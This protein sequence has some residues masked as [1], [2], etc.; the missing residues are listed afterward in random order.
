MTWGAFGY[1]CYQYYQYYQDPKITPTNVVDEYF[2][3]AVKYVDKSYRKVADLFTK[4]AMDKLLPEIPMELYPPGFDFP[5]TLLIN[6]TGTTIHT[7]FEL[8]KG[9]EVIKRPG[10]DDLIK[11]FGQRCEIVIFSDDEPM[12]LQSIAP[13]LDPS[14]QRI[15]GVLGHESMVLEGTRRI[16]DLKYINRDI[17]KVVVIESNPDRL[18]YHVEN[19]IYLSNYDGNPDDKELY[20]LMPFLEYL[21]SPAVK[22]VREELKKFGNHNPA[23]KYMEQ[24]NKR[25]QEIQNKGKGALSGILSSKN[26]NFSRNY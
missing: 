25:K 5:K 14:Q 23:D 8:G 13:R 11:Y 7:Q 17:K 6:L 26:N 24:L 22:D 9:R 15:S 16:K 20:K 19:G 10:F 1:W 21:L 12:F 2:L 4:P 3:E 18:K